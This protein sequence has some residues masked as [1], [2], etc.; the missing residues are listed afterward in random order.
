MTNR[1]KAIEWWN[2]LNDV[3]QHEYRKDYV[4]QRGIPA[5]GK[6]LT[7]REIEK[8]WEYHMIQNSPFMDDLMYL[9][10]QYHRNIKTKPHFK[11]E[12]EHSVRELE[13]L[14]KEYVEYIHQ[15]QII[16][17]GVMEIVAISKL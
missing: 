1:E 9:P 2:S 17:Q 3:E 12:G 16:K 11:G 7:G 15:Q 10:I 14:C 8:V 4:N 13:K 6:L 5:L